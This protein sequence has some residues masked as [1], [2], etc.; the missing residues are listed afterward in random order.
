MKKQD[1]AII[2]AASIGSLEGV[3]TA[4]AAGADINIH[5]NDGNRA[6]DMAAAYGH[7]EVVSFLL[8]NGAD[9]HAD[10]DAALRMAVSYGHAK[11]VSALLAAGANIHA[12]EDYV[13][14]WAASQKNTE[15]V[16]ILIAGG[17]NIHTTDEWPLRI[18]ATNGHT[19]VVRLLLA[20]GADPIVA[21]QKTDVRTQKIIMKTLD[22]C[23]DVMTSEQRAALLTV[24]G[25]DGFV[26]L[27]AAATSDM[28]Q[29]SLRR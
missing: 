15:M 24:S 18:A 3:K 17:A 4:I 5:D 1:M 16:D 11:I 7:A 25:P 9:I 22:A 23:G 27:R 28:A 21:W 14:Q 6:L 10:Q 8:R 26:G 13:I 20:A 12:A 2:T 29:R 19:G